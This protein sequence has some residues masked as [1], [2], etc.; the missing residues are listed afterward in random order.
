MHRVDLEHERGRGGDTSTL[1]RLQRQGTR[2]HETLSFGENAFTTRPVRSTAPAVRRGTLSIRVHDR[3]GEGP[4]GG[5]EKTAQP[6]HAILLISDGEDHEDQAVEAAKK[7]REA[8]IKLFVLGV[9]TQKGGPIP[10]R[11][12]N[13]NLLTYKKDPR[14]QP[15]VS[16]F[17]PDALIELAGAGGG[18]YW[19]VTN[20]EVEVDE[21]LRDLGAL[22][23][24]DFA[25]ALTGAANRS[26]EFA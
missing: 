19:N 24:T 16:S 21:L 15:I 20:D 22:N 11:D 9:G 1:Q 8:G 2:L 7:I 13:G 17:Q 4:A 5:T 23:R 18:R 14:G 6:S 12:D 10:V 25:S 3:G 26:R